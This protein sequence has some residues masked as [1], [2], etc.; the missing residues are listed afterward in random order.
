MHFFDLFHTFF[1]TFLVSVPFFFVSFSCFFLHYLSSV[2]A[3]G[4]LCWLAPVVQFATHSFLLRFLL[5]TLSSTK[6]G[7]QGNEIASYLFREHGRLQEVSLFSTRREHEL[8]KQRK[9]EG[10]EEGRS[11]KISE[12]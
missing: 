8:G 11:K 10:T 1:V 7:F 5:F 6:S 3:P 2:F 12:D 9:K 4:F